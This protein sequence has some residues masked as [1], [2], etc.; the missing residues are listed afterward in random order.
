MQIIGISKFIISQLSEQ[1]KHKMSF[2]HLNIQHDLLYGLILELP[3]DAIWCLSYPAP[4]ERASKKHLMRDTLGT[5][6]SKNKEER[7]AQFWR[8]WGK[9]QPCKTDSHLISFSEGIIS[10][11]SRYVKTLPRRLVTLECLKDCL[12]SDMFH[13]AVKS[14]YLG[15]SCYHCNVTCGPAEKAGDNSFGG[16]TSAPQDKTLPGFCSHLHGNNSTAFNRVALSAP[17]LICWPWWVCLLLVLLLRMEQWW[18]LSVLSFVM[19][20]L[21]NVPKFW[22]GKTRCLQRNY[23]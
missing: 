18:P 16:G 3:Q 1:T 7:A 22:H 8:Q 20:D 17:S 9:T 19:V 5:I 14:N 15:F 10:E 6:W 12:L 11:T 23:R 21:W 2:V 13:S 4:I